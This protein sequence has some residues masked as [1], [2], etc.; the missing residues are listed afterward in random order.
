MNNYVPN[1]ST[2]E[3]NA[4]LKR[5]DAWN[6]YREYVDLR[7]KKIIVFQFSYVARNYEVGI[8]KLL[9]LCKFHKQCGPQEK[10]I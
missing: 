7:A 10:F 2:L 4:G 1:K 9:S 5:R 6:T 8:M 3:S